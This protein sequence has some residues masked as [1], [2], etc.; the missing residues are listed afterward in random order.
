M[1]NILYRLGAVAARRRLLFLGASLAVLAAALMTA[2]GA[3]GSFA[4]GHAIPGSPGQVALEKAE[5]HFPQDG[6]VEGV[7]LF[8]APNGALITDDVVAQQV[9]AAVDRIGAETAIAEVGDPLAEVSE[10]GR[11]AMASL[12][13]ALPPDTEVDPAVQESVRAA[14]AGFADGGRVLFGGD[15]FEEELNPF[16]TPETIGI[17]V[18]L[19]VL[20]ITFGS[21][22]AAGIPMLTAVLGVGG[23]VAGTLLAA[24]VFDVSQNALTLSIMLG[25]AV[26]I[27]YALL[28]VSRHRAQL[29]RGMAVRESIAMATATA[30]SAVTFAGLTVIIALAGLTVAGV[31]ML[32]SMGLASAGAVAMAVL[33]ALTTLPAVLSLAGERLRPKPSSRAARR[34]LDSRPGLA[35]RWVDVVLRHPRKMLAAVVLLLA[36]AAVPATQLALALN[37]NGSA[38]RASEP[39]QAYDL[40]ADAY[41]PGANGAL[42]VLVEGAAPGATAQTVIDTVTPIPGVAEVNGPLLAPGGT[43]AL[44]EI[45]PATGPRDADTNALVGE[46]RAALEPIGSQT[47]DYVALT[48]LTVVSLDAVDKLNDSLL[49]FTVVVVGLSLI[50]LLIAFRSWTIPLKATAGFL[51]SVGAAFGAMVAVFQWGWLAETLGVPLVGPVPSF[52]PIIVMAVLFGLAMDYEVFLVSAMRE[53]YAKH[54]D[55]QE[56]IRAGSRN[57]GRVV[58]AAAAIMIVVFASFL[59]S[60]DPNV[61]P[62]ALALAFGVF[63]DAFLVRLTLVVAVL[64][65]LGDRAWRLPRA[66]DR[67]VPKVD[68]AGPG[69]AA[70]QPAAREPE[71]AGQR[72]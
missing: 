40:I 55:A 14:G 10:D 34:E 30:G 13:F 3:A 51:L 45:V 9:R 69:L 11:I 32:T 42:G 49:P 28:I 64:K 59:F 2:F 66:L 56:A 44:I 35:A 27:D 20:V 61:M 58:V 36:I 60:H 63:V 17:G 65:L 38:P 70:A 33:L 24:R 21:L 48:G 52:A 43:A 54:R 16:G 22:L 47:G 57:A 8:V 68:V 12:S 37:D 19:I 29:V 46:L 7:V 5:Q 71:L 26:G 15:A 1:A 67:I 50:L 62:I 53:H 39:R 18:A 6:G 25:L 72:G 31:P 4:P 23:T 41:G